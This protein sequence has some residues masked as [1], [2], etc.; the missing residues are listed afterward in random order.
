MPT[1]P[2]LPRPI[3]YQ[4]PS[5]SGDTHDSDISVHFAGQIREVAAFGGTKSRNS[6]SESC[7][8]SVATLDK[9]SGFCERRP[10]SA[11]TLDRRAIR[12]YSGKTSIRQPTV[13]QLV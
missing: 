8:E 6:A 12:K 10:I 9:V 13:S 4:W 11:E 2:G 3:V 1:S 5:T 7:G